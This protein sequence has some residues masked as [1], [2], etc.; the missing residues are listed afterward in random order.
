MPRETRAARVL[1]WCVLL[2]ALLTV[3]GCAVTPARVESANQ[4]PS[5]HPLAPLEPA[6]GVYFGVNLDLTSDDVAS[7]AARLGRPPGVYVAF[8]HFPMNDADVVRVDRF[9]DQVHDEG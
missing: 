6:N 7:F 8:T 5:S 1:T 2:S 9:I 3:F 4:P